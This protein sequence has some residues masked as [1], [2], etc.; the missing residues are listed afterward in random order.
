MHQTS[1]H[2]WCQL[3]I[4]FKLRKKYVT[5]SM[6]FNLSLN[7]TDTDSTDRSKMTSCSLISNRGL[8][9]VP[10]SEL[11][12]KWASGRGGNGRVKW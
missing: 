7:F 2:F 4:N 6:G 9:E 8:G 5:Y 12:L 10:G 11:S 1:R 3:Y